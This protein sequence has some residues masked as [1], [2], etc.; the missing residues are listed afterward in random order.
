MVSP[1][2]IDMVHRRILF[3]FSQQ[4]TSTCSQSTSTPS[5]ISGLHGR[6][7]KV[8]RGAN[9]SLVHVQHWHHC[10]IA[11]EKARRASCE[12]FF[13]GKVLLL[14]VLYWLSLHVSSSR[15]CSTGQCAQDH[16][17]GRSAL[18]PKTCQRDYPKHGFHFSHFGF[19]SYVCDFS[20]SDFAFRHSN[21]SSFRFA[22]S[23]FRYLIFQISGFTIAGF[24]PQQTI[25][26]SA[27]TFHLS[28]FRY[29][30][31]GI[32]KDLARPRGNCST[33]HYCDFRRTIPLSAFTFH[34]SHFRY[35]YGGLQKD[36]ARPRG[37][38]STFR[39]CDFIDQVS[40]FKFTGGLVIIAVFAC[41]FCFYFSSFTF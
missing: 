12:F 10:H 18:L 28:H 37:N 19:W 35:R 33:F 38:R 16:Q 21:F 32:Q 29:R 2:C 40:D 31:C 24:R 22:N 4:S 9:G 26:L 20:T 30:S 39:Y 36:L 3:A 34:L 1:Q 5:F 15:L 14:L 41:M 13:Y 7:H 27:C 8:S 17:A 23:H 25:P 6:I 11:S